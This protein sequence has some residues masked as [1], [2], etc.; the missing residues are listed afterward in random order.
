M[1]LSSSD[2]ISVISNFFI[3]SCT[4]VPWL[5][6]APFSFCSIAV[7]MVGRSVATNRERVDPSSSIT[8]HAVPRSH[9]LVRCLS[10]A[11]EVANCLP[12]ASH[13]MPIW[14]LALFETWP[15][16]MLF[17]R[18]VQQIKNLQFKKFKPLRMCENDCYH[19]FHAV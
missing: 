19:R 15:S 1:I 12:Q 11:F 9:P 14:R 17:T 8:S 16:S 10:H 2:Q 3:P 18:N 13:T 7:D 6:R 5:L 4:A